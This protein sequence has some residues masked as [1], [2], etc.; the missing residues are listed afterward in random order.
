MMDEIPEVKIHNYI[1]KNDGGLK[2]TDKTYIWGFEEP[3]FSNGAVYADLDNDGDLDIVIN[4]I[5]DPA[6]VYENNINDSKNK[7]VHFLSVKFSGSEKNRNGIGAT[8][9]VFQ[10]G[11]A[12]TYD[13][14]PFRGYIS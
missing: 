4:N 11:L 2:F 14:N 3:S 8:L 10:K 7:N 6:M 9:Q 1:Y 5:D 12:Q 13:N